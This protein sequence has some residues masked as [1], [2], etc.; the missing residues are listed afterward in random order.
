[1]HVDTLLRNLRGRAALAGCMWAE[2]VEDLNIDGQCR[3]DRNVFI[4]CHQTTDLSPL[5]F[6]R[7]V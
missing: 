2:E 1:M 3:F 4:V 7:V 5:N 6:D